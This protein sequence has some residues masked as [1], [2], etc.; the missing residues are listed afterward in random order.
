M[1]I[2]FKCY[3]GSKLYG[4]FCEGTSDLD[5]MG[6]YLPDFED[7]VLGRVKKTISLNTKQDVNAKNTKDD[8][9]E[10]Y[11]SLQ[12]FLE[13]ACKGETFTQDMLHC[14][15]ENTL[16]SSF[17]WEY[18]K[19]NRNLFYSK[20][21]SAFIQYTLNQTA[22]Y[23]IKGSRL[24]AIR[25]ARDL[26]KQVCVTKPDA[27]LKD[28]PAVLHQLITSHQEYCRF[29]IREADKTSEFEICGKKMQLTAKASYFLE[30]LERFYNS[31]GGRA[32]LAMENKGLDFKAISHC[33]RAIYQLEEIVLTGD[34]KYPLKEADFLRDV[35]LGKKHFIN[36][37]IRDLIENKT[38][39]LK[40]L[41]EKSNLRESVDTEFWDKFVVGIYTGEVSTRG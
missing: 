2:L 27:K 3:Y 23:C 12:Y 39:E 11:Y 34:L 15:K 29:D 4:T 28:I 8:V 7:V 26:V 41:V 33:L 14:N 22:K 21:M 5:I 10:E 24:D 40:Q 35:K 31:Y 13:L 36:D 19:A 6:I 32:I 1:K 25:D 30:M 16:V 37:G 18:I 38:L 20:R 9:D 17:V